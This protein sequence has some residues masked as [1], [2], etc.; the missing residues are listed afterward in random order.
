MVWPGLPYQH[1]HD[2]LISTEIVLADNT[3]LTAIIRCLGLNCTQQYCILSLSFLAGPQ[4]QLK[5]IQKSNYYKLVDHTFNNH[6]T[7]LV[8]R[9]VFCWRRWGSSHPGL[10]MLDPLLSPP[11]T[12]AEIVR[13]MCLQSHFQTSPPTPQK[14]YPKFWNPR[15]IFEILEIKNP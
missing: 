9:R 8:G 15:I 11:S 10:R 4:P 1:W 6:S 12:P 2:R 5:T 13:R 7:K 14:S 3:G